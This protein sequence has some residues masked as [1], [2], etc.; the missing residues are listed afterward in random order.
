MTPMAWRTPSASVT[1]SCP[2][3][4]AVP[5]VGG[6]SVVIMRISVVL[7]APFGPEQAED[8][9]RVNRE[10]H[11]LH[12]HEVSELFRQLD[13]FDC[14]C[15]G[16]VHRVR[17]SSSAIIQ[18]LSC[19]GVHRRNQPLP[20][21]SRGRKRRQQHR[22][23]HARHEPAPGIGHRHLDGKC[24]DVALGPADVALRR[25]IVFD[26]FE[27]DRTFDDVSGRK[28]DLQMLVEL[29]RIDVAFLHVGLHPE[30]VDIEN[31]HDRL[32]RLQDFSLAGRAHGDDAVE[33]RVNLHVSEVHIGRGLIRARL[34]EVARASPPGRFAGRPVACGWRAPR[35]LALPR[36]APGLRGI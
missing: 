26:A 5:E 24:L 35:R 8:F 10:A 17:W 2:A 6:V 32:A 3:T 16:R 33:R 36:R 18:R 15:L 1:T 22:G 25:K 30:M 27:D 29:N 11:F 14:V 31:R 28:P 19:R 21:A 4:T 12:G 7:P 13:D 34:H 20:P 9:A 23:G